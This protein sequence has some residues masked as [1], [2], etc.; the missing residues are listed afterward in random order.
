MGNRKHLQ[1]RAA[2]LVA[3][4]AAGTPPVFTLADAAV[5]LGLSSPAATAML[6]DLVFRGW[7]V[8]HRSGVFEIAPLWAT[9]DAPFEPDRF[10]ALTEWMQEPYYVA[11]RSACEIRDW[12]EHPVRNRLWIAVPRTYRWA[13]A[14]A[15]DRVTF[16]EMA[17]HR[18]DWGLAKH[19]IG[20]RALTVS[21][22]ERTILDC[23]HLPRHGGGIAEVARVL[24]RA[25]PD[26]DEHRLLDHTE[27]LGID[28]VRRRLGLLIDVMSLPHSDLVT[29]GLREQM[30]DARRSPVLLDPDLPVD[31]VVD[32]VW[33]VRVNFD[34]AELAE[35][36]TT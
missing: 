1:G 6:S 4:F 32:R 17:P 14:T 23:L 34:R 25:W 36:G 21:D 20:E 35:A 27:R 8:R 16:V 13:P 7:V 15:R 5:Y 19:W 33:G 30:S 3:H 9:R 18:F 2:D 10:A 11:F 24:R 12:T 22:P 28:A 29:M 26:L 31:G